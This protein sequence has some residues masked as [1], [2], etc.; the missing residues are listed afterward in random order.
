MRNKIFFFAH[1]AKKHFPPK[2]KKKQLKDS[3]SDDTL[4]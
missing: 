2:E 4:F 1:N 3:D